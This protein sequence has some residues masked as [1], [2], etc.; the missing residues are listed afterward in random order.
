MSFVNLIVSKLYMHN[1]LITIINKY[2]KFHRN[3]LILQ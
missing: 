1:K 2:I 3:W